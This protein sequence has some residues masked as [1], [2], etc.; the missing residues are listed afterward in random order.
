MKQLTISERERDF[1]RSIVEYFSESLT[2]QNYV[3]TKKG[4]KFTEEEMIKLE[5]KL[6]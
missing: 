6:K 2:T 3:T 5:D 4:Y 1:L